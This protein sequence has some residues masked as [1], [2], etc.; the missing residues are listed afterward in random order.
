MHTFFIFFERLRLGSLLQQR[1]ARAT[2]QGST[3]TSMP[4][5]VTSL[6]APLAGFNIRQ[7][8]SSCETSEQLAEGH[9]L[10]L[11]GMEFEQVPQQNSLDRYCQECNKYFPFPAALSRH[12]RTHS[13]ERPFPCSECPYRAKHRFDLKKHLISIHKQEQQR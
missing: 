9:S 12:M 7:T 8:Q 1:N 5:F 11:Q 2:V 3:S 13:G 10:L 6:G 4:S